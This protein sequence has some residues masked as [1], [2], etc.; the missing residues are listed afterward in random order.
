MSKPSSSLRL[1]DS[2]DPRLPSRLKPLAAALGGLLLAAAAETQAAKLQRFTSLYAQATVFR[3]NNGNGRQ[4]R[5]ERSATTDDRGGFSLAKGKGPLYL[6]GGTDLATG[7]PNAILL[8]APAPSRAV[9]TVTAVWQALLDRGQSNR[10]IKRLLG[11]PNTAKVADFTALPAADATSAT[12]QNQ[13]LLVKDRQQSTLVRFVKG[14][15]L[16]PAAQRAG[17]TATAGD[18]PPGTVED[19]VIGALADALLGLNRAAADLADPTT[20][21]AILTPMLSETGASLAVAEVGTLAAVASQINAQIA[22]NPGNLALLEV[23]QANAAATAA[24]RDFSTLAQQYMDAG[25][26]AQTQGA[27][28]IPAPSI[29]AL[30]DDA[31]ASATDGITNDATPALSGTASG[32]AAQVRVFADGV[33]VATV[34]VSGGAWTYTSEAALADGAY[35]FTAKGVDSAGREGLASASFAV[36]IDTTPPAPTV[37]V[38]AVTADNAV[39]AAEAA[40]TVTV[41][42]TIAGVNPGDPVTLAVNGATF[43]GVVAADGSFA[44]AVPGADLAAASSLHASVATQDAAGN[45]GGAALDHAYSVDTAPPAPTI[46]VNAITADNTINAAEAAGMLTVGGK[47]TGAN[48]GSAVTLAVNG[49]TFAD[50]VKADGSFAIAV[51]GSALTATGAS[52]RARVAASDAAGNT[53]SATIDHA[54][55]VDTTPPAPTLTVNAVTADNT[56]NAAEAA[57]TITVSGA[58]T[59][60]SSGSAVTLLVNGATFTGAVAANGSY[61]IAV[62]G[63]ALAATSSLRASV[64]ASDAAGNTGS[65]A[66]DHAYSVDTAPP[67]PTITVN[68]VTADNT[69]NAAEAAGTVTVSGATTGASSGSAVTLLVN[70]ATF[71]GAVAANGSYAIAVPGSALAAA[72]SLRASVSASDA[73]GNTG[74]AAFDHAYSVDTTPPTAATVTPLSTPS[75]TPALSGTWSG[76]TGETLGIAIGNQSFTAA[77]GLSVTGSDWSLTPAAPLATGL[78]DVVATATDPAGNSQVDAFPNALSITL[79]VQIVRASVASDGTEANLQSGNSLANGV[80][81]HARFS[82]LSSDGRYVAFQSDAS[83]LVNGDTNGTT[84]I[85]RRDNQTGAVIRVSVSAQGAEGDG[86]SGGRNLGISADGRY[87]AFVSMANNLVPDDSNPSSDIFLRDNNAPG[88]ITRVSVRSDGSSLPSNSYHPSVSAD[89]RFVTFG[90]SASDLDVNYSGRIK[91]VYLH[92]TNPLTPVTVLVPVASDGTAGNDLSYS[93]AISAD[94]RYVAFISKST[95]LVTGNIDTND[96]NNDYDVFLRDLQNGGVV[97]ISVASD[98]TGANGYNGTNPS[99][100]AD[101]R[102]VAF[103]SKAT[104]LEPAVTDTNGLMDIFVRDTQGAG[105]TRLVS[106]AL[107]GETG[108]NSSTTPSISADGRY[109]VFQSSASNLVPGDTNGVSDIFLR[110]LQTNTTLRLSVRSD[111]A[112]GD[113]DSYSPVISADGRFVAFSSLSTNLLPAGQDSNGVQDIFIASGGWPIGP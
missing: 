68:A 44:I 42:G 90:S 51:P 39:N 15:A 31:G 86:Y 93:G 29:L 32:S 19:P 58:T 4:D 91:D 74:S 18:A 48:P 41:S 82:A 63:S 66:L 71:T 27:V 64:S 98:G 3:D 7:Q 38:T 97:R 111:G 80:D 83:N 102:F 96:T 113:G 33:A 105:A 79:P 12:S 62:P 26:Q 35:A 46:A 50:V 78:Y 43:A 87:V 109:V 28:F 53:G 55:I 76:G 61:A 101:G 8:K 34:A 108:N 72:S 84:D 100:S 89:G 36:A 9:G 14:L 45:P 5:K 67:V 75:L 47:T 99:I 37:A 1:C 30:A 110:D 56:V 17:R 77:N 107:N 13:T 6:Q 60:A 2:G 49:A 52:L 85:F 20:V 73:A 95:N 25:L 69:V 23:I 21:E 40:G 59:G 104:N 57:G 106:V 112:E 65:A 16:G 22:Q 103:E 81:G 11:L 94:G 70:G 92:D 54:Y 88:A 24:A 10:K